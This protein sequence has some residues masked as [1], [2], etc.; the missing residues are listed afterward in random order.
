MKKILTTLVLVA[1]SSGL[2]AQILISDF[3]NLNAQ[4]FDFNNSWFFGSSNQ[5]IQDNGFISITPVN[6]GDPKGDGNFSAALDGTAPLDFSSITQLSLTARI[7]TG[8]QN[9]SVVIVVFDSLFDQIGLATFDSSLF[10]SSFSVAQSPFIFGGGG[11]ATDAFYWV[12]GGDGSAGNSVRMSFDNV[13]AV[14]EPATLALV[15]LGLVGLAAVRR[16]R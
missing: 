11:V 13:S 15:G 3:S 4:L 8:N 12:L 7:D 6:G 9:G 16:R 10:T 2:Q 5:Y 1:M 14:P